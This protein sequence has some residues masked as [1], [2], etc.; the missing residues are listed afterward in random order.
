MIDLLALRWVGRKDR[1][2]IRLDFCSRKTSRSGRV[3]YLCYLPHRFKSGFREVLKWHQGRREQQ[4][5]LRQL[6][7][8]F[9]HDSIPHNGESVGGF[10]C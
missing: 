4:P 5:Q 6:K 8:H 7:S 3:R 1:M 10:I 9:G 2:L